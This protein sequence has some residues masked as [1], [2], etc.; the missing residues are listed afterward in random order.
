MKTALINDIW[1]ALNEIPDPEIPPV[2]LVELGI[3]RD[4]IVTPKGGIKVIMTPTFSGC[5]ALHRMKEDIQSKLTE[6]N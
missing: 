4:V 2:S 6:M 5:P 1:E 3:I